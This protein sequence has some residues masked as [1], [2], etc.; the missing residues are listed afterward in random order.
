MIVVIL[1]AIQIIRDTRR[2][3]GGKTKCHMKFFTALNSDFKA[4]G[5]KVMFERAE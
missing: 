4:F 3:G 5:S 2:G 1:G